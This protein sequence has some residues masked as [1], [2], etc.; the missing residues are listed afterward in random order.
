VILQGG[1][2]TGRVPVPVAVDAGD[3]TV[4]ELL[5]DE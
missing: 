1:A 4:G 2:D 3:V 5:A